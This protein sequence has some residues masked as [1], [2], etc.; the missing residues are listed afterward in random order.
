MTPLDAHDNKR[1]R[2]LLVF[3]LGVARSG[4]SALTR[5]LSL[6]GLA[7]PSG[8]L[9]AGKHNRRGYWEPRDAII[10]NS[11]FLARCGSSW[12][13]PS[14]RLSEDGGIDPK[15]RAD[16]IAD[17]VAYLKRMPPAPATVIKELRITALSDMWFEAAELAGFDTAA[18]IA[19][20]HP[21]EVVAS[22]AEA[23]KAP[24][25]LAGALWL[26]YSLMA[27]KSTRGMPRVFVDYAE[28]LDDWRRESKRIST[29]LALDL[30][31]T[32]E[33]AIDDFLSPDLQH[34][35]YSGPVEDPFSSD[36]MTVVYEATAAAARDELLD[37]PAL[38][39]VYREYQVNERCFR[40]AFDG[41]RGYVNSLLN[42]LSH[43]V[44][45]KPVFEL[46]AMARMR[47][48]SWA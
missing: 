10:L 27:E 45:M 4:T 6:S 32:D 36:W 31:A 9:G 48:G 5:V 21:H 43:P 40:L 20:R 42:R 22:L 2:P 39:R 13:D 3:V 37:I 12:W 1:N 7:L 30:D 29:T 44:L 46:Q 8:M 47:R 19:V 18:V 15:L 34:Q 14:L 25:E 24:Q 26:K 16:Q 28:L 41:S 23:G 33:G 11:S 38:D 17:I 35:R